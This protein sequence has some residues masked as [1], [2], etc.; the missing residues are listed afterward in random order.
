MLQNI[1]L[2]SSSNVLKDNYYIATR[3]ASPVLRTCD[4][5]L[6]CNKVISHAELSSNT[7]Y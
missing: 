4:V 6:Y 1:T 7:N 2:F 3:N 5:F